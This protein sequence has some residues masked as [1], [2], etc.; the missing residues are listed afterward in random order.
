[1]NSHDDVNS[2]LSLEPLFRSQLRGMLL[3]LYLA[4]GVYFMSQWGA[5]FNLGV[6]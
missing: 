5:V 1:V 6:I 3:I 4:S 2:G